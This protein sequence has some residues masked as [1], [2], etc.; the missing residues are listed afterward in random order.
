MPELAALKYF[1][2]YV[3]TLLSVTMLLVFTAVAI[4]LLCKF[5]YRFITWKI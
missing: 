1:G 2:Q 4:I 5:A 3:A